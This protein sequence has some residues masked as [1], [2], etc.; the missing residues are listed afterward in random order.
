MRNL[1]TFNVEVD[2]KWANVRSPAEGEIWW[3]DLDPTKGHEQAG[4]RPVVVLSLQRFN[5]VTKRLIGVPVTTS[6]APPGSGRAAF[7]VPLSGCE[8]PS[9]ALP[10]QI[11][12]LDWEA[13]KATFTGWK[14]TE[15][16]MDEIWLRIRGIC[17]R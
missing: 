3:V 17:G 7:Q 1:K 4:H 10:D 13:R 6:I 12:T 2:V 16:E 5:G 9:A 11:T 15:A 8:K 14:A